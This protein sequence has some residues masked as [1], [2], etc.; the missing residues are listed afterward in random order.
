MKVTTISVEHEKRVSNG[1][2]GSEMFKVRLDAETDGYPDEDMQVLLAR[3]RDMVRAELRRSENITV[4]RSVNPRPHVCNHCAQPLDDW[5][6]Y[7][8]QACEEK[9][10]AERDARREAERLVPLPGRTQD[11]PMP[12]SGVITLERST[13]QNGED[14]EAEQ[15]LGD[16]DDER[17]IPF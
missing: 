2:Y 15:D 5:E 6:T 8:H 16:E 17:G 11:W 4:R 13:G 3:A 7:T 9:A 12:G 10:R 1:D 14:I